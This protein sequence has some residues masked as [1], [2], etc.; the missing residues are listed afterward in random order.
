M[1][2]EGIQQLSV[3][4]LLLAVFGLTFL[5]NHVNRSRRINPE[6]QFILVGICFD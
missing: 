4:F 6:E 5:A 3:L 2:D 1:L